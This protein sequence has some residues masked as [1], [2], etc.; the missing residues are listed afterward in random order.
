MNDISLF[1]QLPV[2][3][4]SWRFCE[5]SSYPGIFIV[6]VDNSTLFSLVDIYIFSFDCSALLLNCLAAGCIWI[7]TQWIH[8]A[9]CS[10]WLEVCTGLNFTSRPSLVRWIFGLVRLSSVLLGLAWQSPLTSGLGL[11]TSSRWI[12]NFILKTSGH[13]QYSYFSADNWQLVWC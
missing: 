4:I 3:S 9:V 11:F 5:G 1:H 10:N 13:T 8:S 6:V 12:Y 7:V 2:C